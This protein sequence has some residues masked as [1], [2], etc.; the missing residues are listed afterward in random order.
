[1]IGR[2]RAASIAVVISV[3]IVYLVCVCVCV[4]VLFA[5][6]ASSVLARQCLDQL[7][8]INKQVKRMITNRNLDHCLANGAGLVLVECLNCCALDLDH[9]VCLCVVVVCHDCIIPSRSS[10]VKTNRILFQTFW[11]VFYLACRLYNQGK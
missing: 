2:T 10:I 6:S 11:K 4:C 1:M 7:V 9:S 5:C 8:L 3:S